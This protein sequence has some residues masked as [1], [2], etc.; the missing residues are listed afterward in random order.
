MTKKIKVLSPALSLTK[1]DYKKIL[2]GGLIAL[3]GAGIT[4]LVQLPEMINWGT[5]SP[6][7]AALCS[8]GINAIR[9]YVLKK[10]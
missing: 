3:G 4:F 2:I 7:V 9:K 5:W 1:D 10:E 6:L 8:I